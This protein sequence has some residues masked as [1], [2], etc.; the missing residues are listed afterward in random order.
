[1]LRR[2][3]LLFILFY[4]AFVFASDGDEKPVFVHCVKKCINSTCPTQLDFTLRLLKW[5]C[6]EN[7]RYTCMQNITDKAIANHTTVYQYYGKWPFYRFFGIQEPASVLF[8]IG[9]GL[10]QGYYFFQL[11]RHTPS[12]YA[13]RPLLLLYTLIGMNAWVWSTIFHS[14]D[15][16]LTTLMDYFSAALYVLYSLYFAIVRVCRIQKKSTM[17][18]LAVVCSCFYAAHI[19]YL[20][21]YEFD[22]VYNMMANVMVGTLQVLVWVCWYVLQKLD[23]HAIDRPYAYL[24]VMSGMGVSLA[25]SLELFDFP[26][27]WRVFDAH[28]LWH[29]S[30]IPL[31]IIW[32]RFLMEDMTFE[33][34]GKPYQMKLLPS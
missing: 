25:L 19:I 31:T 2:T 30:T 15:K 5:T 26:P 9:N 3:F 14:R 18:A 10:V 20:T 29:F 17:I 6:P 4:A 11:H 32:Y 1:M 34:S 7:C 28:S 8:S 27:L 23:C 21:C 13:L 33:T 22:Y 12:N 24:A 16:R